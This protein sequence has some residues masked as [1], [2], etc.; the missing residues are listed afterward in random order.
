MENV[1]LYD[2]ET[3]REMFLVVVY[4]PKEGFRKWEISKWRNEIDGFVKFTEEYSNWWWCGYNN[5]SFDSQIVEWILRNHQEWNELSSLEITEKIAQ[6]A[7]DRISDANYDIF[8]EY[9]EESLSLKQIDLFTIWHFNNRNKS[10]SLK[11]LEFFMKM[12]NIEETPVPFN[13][14]DLSREECVDVI[15]YCINDVKATYQFYLYTIGETNHPLY[16]GKN[17]INDRLILEKEIGLKCLNYDDVR[18][19]AEWNKL[20]YIK[21]TGKNEKQLKPQRVNHFFG[22]KYKQFFPKTVEF[23]TP[24]LRE[25]IRNFGETFILNKKQEF[26]FNFSQLEKYKQ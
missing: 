12:E 19:G 10:M 6:K 16:K 3:L 7:Q 11:G 26:T 21:L 23:Q 2:I 20:D 5:L 24:E 9:R 15:K 17:K 4:I 1:L 18:I 22:K 8:P 13:K 25:F 14:S